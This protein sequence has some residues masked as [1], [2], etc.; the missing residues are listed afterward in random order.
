MNVLLL[1]EARWSQAYEAAKNLQFRGP[2][3]ATPLYGVPISVKDC[4]GQQGAYST[5]GLA[6]RLNRRDTI[7]S[8]I[9]Q[10]LKSSGALPLCR[11][12]V[13]QI[14]M[15]AETTNFIWGRSRNPW[16]LSRTPG[17]SSGGDAALVAM[18]CVPLAVC[19][20]VA[21]SIRIPSAFCGVTG[22][23]PTST[24]LSSEGNMK[25]RKVRCQLDLSYS[26]VNKDE[27]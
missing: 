13:P 4:I 11:G 5:G 2:H 7:D 16:D 24:R 17:G 10:V 19:S 14:M 27:I 22:F 18:G 15:I 3:G 21:G 23:K 26:E 25:P 12:N 8:L 20:D 6:C 9:V 1:N